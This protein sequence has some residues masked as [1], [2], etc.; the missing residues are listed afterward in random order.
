MGLD[1]LRMTHTSSKVRD[2]R[3]SDSVTYTCMLLLCCHIHVSLGEEADGELIVLR[4]DSSDL[5]SSI[6]NVWIS[7]NLRCLQFEAIP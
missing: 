2:D 4:R 5:L 1:S 6:H 7:P 3:I